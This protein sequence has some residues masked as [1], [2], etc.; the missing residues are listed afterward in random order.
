MGIFYST[1]PIER[2]KSRLDFLGKTKGKPG[3]QAYLAD[4]QDLEDANGVGTAGDLDPDEIKAV[5]H[6]HSLVIP[7]VP[8]D[9][10]GLIDE[11]FPT[12]DLPES[13][14]EDRPL[15]LGRRGNLNAD[16]HRPAAGG[17][18]IGTHENQPCDGRSRLGRGPCSR[19]CWRRR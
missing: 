3:R 18:G 5:G 9:D 11:S 13:L 6:G 1:R 14:G 16:I 8:L 10:T 17:I 12:A 2:V 19:R 4:D 7:K 15:D